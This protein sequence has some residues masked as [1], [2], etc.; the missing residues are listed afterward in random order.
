MHTPH[1]GELSKG[2]KQRPC[3][4]VQWLLPAAHSGIPR[5]FSRLYVWPTPAYSL[6]ATFV[7][8]T[9]LFVERDVA[10][11]RDVGRRRTSTETSI[12]LLK[13][14]GRVERWIGKFGVLAGDDFAGVGL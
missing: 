2:A 11:V 3:H 10:C 13:F 1:V 9:C 12:D 5:T 8:G 6:S 4:C 7:M 14:R